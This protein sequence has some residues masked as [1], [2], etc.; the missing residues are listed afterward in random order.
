MSQNDITVVGNLT[1]DPEL[2][3]T[4]SGASVVSFTVACSKRKYD[5]STQ[6]WKDGDP[7]YWRCSVWRQQA[8]NVA[9]TLTKGNRVIVT[10]EVVDS[11]FTTKEGENRTVK[12]IQVSEVAASLLFATATI[13]RNPHNTNNNTGGGYSDTT[14]AATAAPAAAPF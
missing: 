6:S 2:R 1:A 13:N 8:E 5:S 11:K 14:P 3:Y 7:V 12:E 10:G 4:P 9:E